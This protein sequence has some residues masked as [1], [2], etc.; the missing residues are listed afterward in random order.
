MIH[1]HHKQEE[2]NPFGARR[3]YKGEITTQQT[4]KQGLGS[5]EFNPAEYIFSPVSGFPTLS[6]QERLSINLIKFMMLSQGKEFDPQTIN[7]YKKQEPTQS[8]LTTAFAQSPSP[9]TLV[10]TTPA[11]ALATSFHKQFLNQY[12]P[13]KVAQQEQW[14]NRYVPS[15]K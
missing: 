13:F 8:I 7:Q 9:A 1:L 4:Q 5:F 15:Q 12:A 3:F 14:K 2:F 11:T 6:P 10:P